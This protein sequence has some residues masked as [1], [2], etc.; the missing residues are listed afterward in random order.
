MAT[1]C[2]SW[3]RRLHRRVG[4][5]LVVGG[6]RLSDRVAESD[7]VQNDLLSVLFVILHPLVPNLLSFSKAEDLSQPLLEAQTLQA[8]ALSNLRAKK[9]VM[10]AAL[11]PPASRSLKRVDRGMERSGSHRH[12]SLYFDKRW[13]ERKG[14]A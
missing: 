1:F 10:D 3:T 8:Q 4:Y 14:A 7:S 11:S 12:P 13:L 9:T 5:V 6:L 2:L